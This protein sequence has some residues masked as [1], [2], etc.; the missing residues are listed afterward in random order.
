MG[1]SLVLVLRWS[2]LGAV[3]RDPV[4]LFPLPSSPSAAVG[5]WI[6][7]LQA[8]TFHPC[9]TLSPWRPFLRGENQVT[10]LRLLGVF[11]MIPFPQEESAGAVT[12]CSVSS[13]RPGVF[14][15][16]LQITA[17]L[18]TSR[19]VSTKEQFRCSFHYS[20]S[21]ST[22]LITSFQVSLYQLDLLVA[23]QF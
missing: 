23:V 17:A 14:G 11:S 7:P 21:S 22:C 16:N 19:D 12:S 20:F 1:L 13:A 15:V 8:V 18:N 3:I 6:C 2:Q 4:K 9:S 5:I 10:D